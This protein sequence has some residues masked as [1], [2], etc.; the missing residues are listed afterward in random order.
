VS[1]AGLL[2]VGRPAL[3]RWAQNTPSV[4]MNAGALVGRD[5]RVL[6]TVTDRTGRVKLAGEVWSARTAPGH[7]SLEVGSAV[8]VVRID[9]AT[10]V[11]APDPA[12][13]A[14]HSL[15]GRPTP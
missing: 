9:G 3:K 8:H 2:F 6:E 12:P 10:A 4:T 7:S 15:E 13:P 14:P 1:S 11:V 5:A